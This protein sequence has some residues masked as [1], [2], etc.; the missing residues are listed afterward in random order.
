MKNKELATKFGADPLDTRLR[1]AK[2]G[3]DWRGLGTPGEAQIGGAGG[4][5][6]A[7]DFAALTGAQRDAERRSKRARQNAQRGG[8][9]EGEK[10]ARKS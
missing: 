2:T 8:Q 6:F 5:A 7:L 1:G 9:K 3:A 4:T 10:G